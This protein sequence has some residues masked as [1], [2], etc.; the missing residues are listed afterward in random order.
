VIARADTGPKPRRATFT[1]D[2]TQAFNMFVSNFGP[3]TAD[4]TLTVRVRQ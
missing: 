1:N 4:V 3:G 2:R